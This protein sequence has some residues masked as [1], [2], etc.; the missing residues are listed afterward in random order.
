MGR[1]E[2]WEGEFL[3]IRDM[4]LQA[5]EDAIGARNLRMGISY[6]WNFMEKQR[7]AMKNSVGTRVD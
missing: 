3:Q 5:L 6:S 7:P 4:A 2:A 1:P